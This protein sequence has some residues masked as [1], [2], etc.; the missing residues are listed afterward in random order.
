MMSAVIAISI[1]IQIVMVPLRITYVTVMYG[2]QLRR[3]ELGPVNHAFAV[4]MPMYAPGHGYPQTGYGYPPASQNP[5]YGSQPDYG[6]YAQQPPQYGQQPGQ[7]PYGQQP[8][9]G[10]G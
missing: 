1:A 10:R 7:P 4:N 6:S 8:P 9:F 2:D 3:L 5:G